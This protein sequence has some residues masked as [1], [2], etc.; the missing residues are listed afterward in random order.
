MPIRN[1]CVAIIRVD[2][3]DTR[4][5]EPAVEQHRLAIHGVPLERDDTRGSGLGLFLGGIADDTKSRKIANER[6]FRTFA[7]L[8]IPCSKKQKAAPLRGRSSVAP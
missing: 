1:H 5:D 7:N 8:Q 4:S 3:R 2:G 6:R